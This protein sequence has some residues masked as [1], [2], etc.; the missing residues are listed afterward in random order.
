MTIFSLSFFSPNH[1]I[2]H[3]GIGLDDLDDLIGYILVCIIGDGDT[4]VAVLRHLNSEI[5][6]LQQVLFINAREDKARLVQRLRTLGRGA[7]ANS[8][9]RLADRGKE[10]AFLRKGAAVGYDAEGVHL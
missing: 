6:R 8:G 7:D 4:E 2:H 5:D 3:A 9:D 10:G 1:F